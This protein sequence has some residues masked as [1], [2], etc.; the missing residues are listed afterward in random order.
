M[1]EK[2]K[3]KKKTQKQADI[4]AAGFRLQMKKTNSSNV[5]L[6]DLIGWKMEN[7]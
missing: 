2:K 5:K 6:A 4:K 7:P 3:K 1:A